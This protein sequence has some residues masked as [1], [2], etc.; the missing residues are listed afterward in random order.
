MR[1]DRRVGWAWFDATGGG[2]WRCVMRGHE[3]MPGGHMEAGVGALPQEG[4]RPR[5]APV[6]VRRLT[7]L[8]AVMWVAGCYGW[9][10]RSR[11]SRWADRPL[12][13]SVFPAHPHEPPCLPPT[14]LS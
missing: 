14:P 5:G 7:S 6:R 11:L 8:P 13:G 3:V 9:V 4:I 12:N 2:A 10:T 1:W